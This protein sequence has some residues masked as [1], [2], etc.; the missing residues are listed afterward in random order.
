MRK[1][2]KTKTLVDNYSSNSQK[3]LSDM[4]TFVHDKFKK[5]Y[6]KKIFLPQYSYKIFVQSNM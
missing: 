6:S 5:K 4:E 2:F 3:G 1:K